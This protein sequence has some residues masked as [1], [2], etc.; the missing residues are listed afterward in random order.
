MRTKAHTWAQQYYKTHESKIFNNNKSITEAQLKRKLSQ[1]LRDQI[2]RKNQQQKDLAYK[3]IQV[4]CKDSTQ[5]ALRKDFH[6]NEFKIREL[7]QILK[8]I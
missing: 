5:H 2:K 6:T 1:I 4:E 8:N 3:I 7:Q